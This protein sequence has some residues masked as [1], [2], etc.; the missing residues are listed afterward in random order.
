MEIKLD[1][2]LFH[3]CSKLLNIDK[4]NK[5]LDQQSWR[6]NIDFDNLQQVWIRKSKGDSPFKIL[7]Q[8]S[9]IAE[10][11]EKLIK[12]KKSVLI[13]EFVLRQHQSSINKKSKRKQFKLGKK[14]SSNYKII[15][16]GFLIG[17]WFNKNAN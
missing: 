5:V 16:C 15:Y 4:L 2:P 12:E 1:K 3:E 11:I 13:E 8:I 17:S 7:D 6:D 10:K 14:Y 9:S